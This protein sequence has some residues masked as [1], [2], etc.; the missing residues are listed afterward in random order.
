MRIIHLSKENTQNWQI[1]PSYLCFQ[2]LMRTSKYLLHISYYFLASLEADQKGV[3]VNKILLEIMECGI[4]VA[5]VTFD[6]YK[7]NPAL[8]RLLG[9]NLD[10]FSPSFDPVLTVNN[11]QINIIYDPSHVIKFLRTS[12]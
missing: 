3:L 4:E 11:K 8:C 9:A 6:G 1:R 5:S 10:V 2:E 12:F 7:T